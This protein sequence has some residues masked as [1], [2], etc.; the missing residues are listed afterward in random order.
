MSS[1]LSISGKQLVILCPRRCSKYVSLVYHDSRLSAAR[2]TPAIGHTS[3]Q[4][5]R[6]KDFCRHISVVFI[7]VRLV[8]SAT[9][10]RQYPLSLDIETSSNIESKANLEN[11]GT[12]E[13]CLHENLFVFDKAFAQEIKYLFAELDFDLY[14]CQDKQGG[15]KKRQMVS[16]RIPFWWPKD[17]HQTFVYFIRQNDRGGGIFSNVRDTNVGEYIEQVCLDQVLEAFDEDMKSDGKH[18]PIYTE[19]HLEDM[20]VEDYLLQFETGDAAGNSLKSSHENEPGR[21]DVSVEEY[22]KLCEEERDVTVEGYMT[23]LEKDDLSV[24]TTVEQYLMS[25]KDD[26]E[27]NGISVEE[28]LR[29]CEELKKNRD[30]TVE[31]YLILCKEK[32]LSQDVTVE[33]YLKHCKEELKSRDLTVEEY[34]KLC[35][36]RLSEDI[37]VEEYL[38]LFKEGKS[39]DMTVE[40]Y[41]RLCEKDQ[42]HYDI[43]VE[44]YLNLHQEQHF[45]K[46]VTIEEYLQLC[47]GEK[48]SRDMT[49]EEYL[50]LCEEEKRSRDMT[51][52]EYLQLCEEEKRSRDMTVEEYLQL[53]E[54][55]KRSR[56]MTVEE[57]LQLCEEEKRSRD[58]TVE[59]YLQMCEEERRSR[60]MTIEE[61]LQLCEEEKRS[62][63][64]TVEE[65]LQ[66]CEEEKRSRDMTV[67]EYLQ[68]CEEE[69]RLRDMTVEECLKL[70]EEEKRSRDMTV[71]EYLQLC[72]KENKSRDLTVEEYLQLCEEERESTD[73]SVEEYLLK[74]QRED[75]ETFDAF[76]NNLYVDFKREISECHGFE[77]VLNK[78]DVHSQYKDDRVMSTEDDNIGYVGS[79]SLHKISL[80]QNPDDV[81]LTAMEKQP[82]SRLQIETEE[83]EIRESVVAQAESS[84][85]DW[86]IFDTVDIGDRESAHDKGTVEEDLFQNVSILQSDENGMEELLQHHG[87]IYSAELWLIFPPYRRNPWINISVMYRDD[88]IFEWGISKVVEAEVCESESVT[89]SETKAFFEEKTAVFSSNE[90]PKC[91]AVE[92]DEVLVSKVEVNFAEVEFSILDSFDDKFMN[93]NTIAFADSY[94]NGHEKDIEHQ[95]LPSNK[96]KKRVHPSLKSANRNSSEEQLNAAGNFAFAPLTHLT[97][98]GLVYRSKERIFTGS[99]AESKSAWS[100]LEKLQCK[101]AKSINL[102]ESLRRTVSKNSLD[103]VEASVED[104][105][106]EQ[107]KQEIETEAASTLITSPLKIENFG[108]NLR[109]SNV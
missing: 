106:N 34:L 36:E 97:K 43:T 67:E 7:S 6:R 54:E 57:Y 25:C 49:V 72:Q 17:Q 59:E 60:D 33:E 101:H 48:Q 37:T 40:E 55:E 75:M 108:K 24:D 56:D 18:L 20:S 63:D 14:M 4:W 68:L 21:K 39:A 46:D 83:D 90:I 77:E 19:E 27:K 44:E 88:V 95:N 85:D 52:E 22:L 15:M 66:L 12:D 26:R 69:K 78:E 53:C 87:L 89:D 28:Y 11:R 13:S 61:Y 64:M 1:K 93:N 45:L 76:K 71:E 10:V 84:V 100:S 8:I 92:E 86:L 74:F 9:W 58:M 109:E 105:Q 103:I 99:D 65:Y 50:Q 30:I 94:Q 104:E 102:P 29:L 23:S 81:G 3:I 79:L 82:R 41:L 2:I 98:K 42:R 5:E 62:R 16:R 47:E 80:D 51:V 32:E 91:L 38:R 70:C 35:N 73:L 96:S 31:E 107:A